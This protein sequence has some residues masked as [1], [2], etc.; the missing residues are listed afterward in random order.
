MIKA[1]KETHAVLE[2]P[3]IL[4]SRIGREA[5]DKLEAGHRGVMGQ[6][7]T[8]PAIA[9]LLASM[10]EPAEGDVR[11]LDLGAGVGTLTA[12]FVEKVLA[13]D[14]R[15][16][17]LHLTAW[18]AETTF[19]GRLEQVLERCAN[20]CQIAGVRA[21]YEVKHGDALLASVALVEDS[22]LFSPPRESPGF[23]HAIM[24]P[25]YRKISADSEARRL[26]RRVG[27]ETSNLYTGFLWLAAR[28]LRQDGEL[29]AITPRSFC[30]GPY[31][32]PFRQRF[33]GLMALERLHIFEER[34]ALFAED[35]VLQENVIMHARRSESRRTSV[36]LSSSTGLLSNN[37]H[38]RT[39]PYPRVLDPKDSEMVVHL[40]LTVADD[41][42]RKAVMGMPSRLADLEIG[43]STG[44]VVDFRAKEF[45]RQE[46]GLGTVPLI[47]PMHFNGGCVH[48]PHPASRKPN[49]LQVVP[50]TE[51]LLVPNGVYVLVK[52]FTAKEERRRV[53]ATVFRPEGG[54]AEFASVGFENHLNYFHHRGG[55]IDGRLAE[56][57]AIFLNSTLVDAYFR[58]FSGHTQVNATDLRNL[59]YPS[60]AQLHWLA[61]TPAAGTRDQEVIDSAVDEMIRR[62]QR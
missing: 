14:K 40:A 39:V 43:V 46:P 36:M 58:Q 9:S 56:G 12:A 32:L 27:L 7:L 20:E 29:V 18:E 2:S 33:F 37:D 26:L 49:A 62:S 28:L 21:S 51:E 8:P 15:P 57:L 13:Q 42:V 3:L 16:E 1:A 35:D 48:W 50:Q 60:Q 61:R 45:L 11:L 10:F 6:F 59:R 55:E 30:N 52:R 22:D 19:V 54:L 24:N 44:R 53:V 17:S 34:G 38:A 4:A 23:T 25:P 31:F 41:A 5:C 47:Y